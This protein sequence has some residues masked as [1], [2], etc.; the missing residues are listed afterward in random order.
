MLPKMPDR[1]SPMGRVRA[2][3]VN[4]AAAKEAMVI[5]TKT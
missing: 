4:A 5:R 3:A 1:A 2:A